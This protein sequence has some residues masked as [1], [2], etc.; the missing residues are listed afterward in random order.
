MASLPFS[1]DFIGA[2]ENPL[3]DGGNWAKLATG[4]QAIRRV[5]NVA[6]AAAYT[7][8]YDDAY[9]LVQIADVAD[10]EV[11]AT[12]YRANAT[13]G[14]Y[15][16]LL[17][18]GDDSS[19]VYGY[20]CL[21]NTSGGVQI[22]RWDMVGGN[23]NDWHDITGATSSPGNLANGHQLR[24]TAIGSTIT[25]YHRTSEVGSWSQIGTASDSQYATGKVGIAHYIHASGGNIDDL[26]FTAFWATPANSPTGTPVLWVR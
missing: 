2:N 24:A 4:W 20:E 5:S 25:F 1:T 18:M 21:C 8:S 10:V 9:S 17:R 19:H 6:K 23:H 22:V 16:L 15:E 11:I 26:G 14:E 12:L 13:F 7:D 3:S